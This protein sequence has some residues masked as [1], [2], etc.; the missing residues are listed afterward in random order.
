LS[1][2]RTVARLTQEILAEKADISV[3]YLQFIEAGRY[4]PTVLVAAR[5]RKALGCRWNDLLGGL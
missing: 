1:R 4:A 5:L 2:L 3:R